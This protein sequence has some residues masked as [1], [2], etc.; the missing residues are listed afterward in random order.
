[1]RGLLVMFEDGILTRISL[2][3]GTGIRT[4]SGIEVGDPATAVMAAHD[5]EA[6]TTP[7]KYQ[8]APRATARSGERAADEWLDTAHPNRFVP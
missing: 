4:A 8:E 2:S 1:M 7:H 6:V 5:A 3:E